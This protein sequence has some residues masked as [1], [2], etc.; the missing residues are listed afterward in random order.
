ML[1]KIYMSSANHHES[2]LTGEK[3]GVSGAEYH[4]FET[5]V[6]DDSSK[7]RQV[8]KA[9]VVFGIS[10]ASKVGESFS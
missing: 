7:D 1:G 8:F 3:K 9:A 10:I 4:S 6:V 5:K 2:V